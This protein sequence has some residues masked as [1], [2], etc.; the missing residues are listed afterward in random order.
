MTKL[1]NYDVFNGDADGICALHQFRL[2]Q[3]AASTLITGVK[4]DIQLLDKVPYHKENRINVF[5]IS[6]DK[7]RAALT[8]HLDTGAS[9]NYFD[10]HFAGNIPHHKQLKTHINTSAEICTSLIVNNHLAHQH[11][12]WA[13]VGGFGDNFDNSAIA[14][15]KQYNDLS[16]S[17]LNQLKQ[18]GILLNYNAYGAKLDDLH[19]TPIDLYKKIAYFVDPL[20]FITTEPVFEM[21]ADGYAEDITKAKRLEPLISKDKYA[22]Y[23]L[24][25]EKWARRASGVFANRLNIQH[26][27]R[28]HALLTDTGEQSWV[29]SVRAPAENKT[30]ADELCRQFP[31][32]GG[33]K[34]AAGINKLAHSDYDKF[35]SK[36]IDQFG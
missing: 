18:L 36:L 27:G 15:S 5:D 21:L 23:L 2:A 25:N 19:I 7:N 24:P 30:G 6:L 12:K 4:R 1:I 34:A 20:E 3:P 29:V 32:G 17:M 16:S 33:R 10:H 26:P 8:Q 14:L 28:A 35:I 31:T 11:Y 13:I 9:I 22:V